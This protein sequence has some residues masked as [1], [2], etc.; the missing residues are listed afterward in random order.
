LSGWNLD[1][2]VNLSEADPQWASIGYNRS[3]TSP[4]TL[5]NV[6]FSSWM[7]DRFN[8]VIFRVTLGVIDFA[9][10]FSQIKQCECREIC[11]CEAVLTRRVCTEEQ[12]AGMGGPAPA[13]V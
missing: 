5:A 3:I 8:T 1:E 9:F 2:I 11:P 6:G 7:R 13:P 12:E 10:W 4:R